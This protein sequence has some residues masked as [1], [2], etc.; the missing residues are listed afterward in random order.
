VEIRVT[1]IFISYSHKDTEYAH[2]LAD[3]LQDKGFAVWIDERL[4]YGSQWPHEIQK[5]LDSC[6]AFIVIM[7]PRSFASE[8]VQSELQRAKRKLKPVL[9]VLLEGDE[10]WLS[11]ESTQYYDV[12][13]GKLPDARFFSVLT[14]LA[15]AGEPDEITAGTSEVADRVPYAR[16]KIRTGLALALMGGAGVLVA[17]CIL[18]IG[19]V[20][21]WNWMNNPPAA[22]EA[23]DPNNTTVRQES[24]LSDSSLPVTGKT[25]TPGPTQTTRPSQT[26]RATQTSKPLPT[27]TPLPPSGTC[28]DGYVPR[29]IKPNDKVCVPPSSKAQ[30]DADT[31]A[32]ESRTIL[33][34]LVN[35]YGPYACAYG[36]V[37]RNAFDGDLVCV[38][39]WVRDQVRDDNTVAQ[40]RWISGEYGPNTCVSGFVWRAAREND[41]VCVTPDQRDQAA[42][43]NAQAESRMA[44]NVYDEYECLSGYAWREA[45]PGDLVCVTP[46]VRDQ[47]TFDNA[48]APKHTWP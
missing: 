24:T 45:F 11:V 46:E 5:Q 10:P 12:R 27:T 32:A 15:P 3:V 20:A 22:P 38:E 8:W 42:S 23:T 13:G 25:S 48:E 41:L 14:R 16:P 47:T 35:A 36:Y 2:K 29:L 18:A 6:F 40:Q 39:S 17:A 44:V 26:L 33:Y 19:G 34:S 1:H 21:L 28:K 37:H 43:D 31:A 4:D 7:S 30:A 9:P